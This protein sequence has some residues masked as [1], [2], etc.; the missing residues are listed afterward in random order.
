MTGQKR[1]EGDVMNVVKLDDIH[2][3]WKVKKKRVKLKLK[4]KLLKLVKRTETGVEAW[5]GMHLSVRYE[6]RYLSV[7]ALKWETKDTT[8][9]YSLRLEKEDGHTGKKE[10]RWKRERG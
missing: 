3:E 2:E 6:S 4:L 9:S 5:W 8:L 10:A 1:K 7:L